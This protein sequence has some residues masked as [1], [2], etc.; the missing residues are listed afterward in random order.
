LISK[1]W[2]AVVG[3]AASISLALTGCSFQQSAATG[4][5]QMS[6]DQVLRIADTGDIPTLDSAKA[7]DVSSMNILNNIQ[8][9]LMR[10]GQDDQPEN[11]IASDYEVSPD[12][13]T[14]TFHLRDDAN[15]S[16]GKPVTADDFRYAWL[17]ALDPKTASQYAYALYPIKN[18]QKYNQ[19][20]ASASQVGIK[21]LDKHTLQVTLERPMLNFISMTTMTVYLP[22]REDIVEKYGSKYGTEADKLVYDGPFTVESW[23][24]QQVILQRNDNYWDS[25]S[26]SLKTV[27]INIIKDLATG[28]NMYNAGQIDIVPLN[29]AFVDAYKQTPDFV[30]VKQ[31]GVYYILLNQKNPFFKNDKIR[32]AITLALDRDQIANRILKD[33]SSPAGSL[34]PPSMNGEANKSF[35]VGGEVVETDVGRAQKLFKE[36]LKELGLSQPPSNIVMVGYDTTARRNVAVNIKEQLRQTLGWDISLD[37]PTW[38]VHLQRAESGNY[39]MMMLGWSADYNDPMQFFE[40]FESNNPMNFSHFSNAKYDQ[41]VEKAKQETN[42][43]QEFLDLSQA[44][45]ILVGTDGEGQAAFVPLFYGGKSYVQ[46]PYVKD[47][48]RHPFGAEYSLKW[49]YITKK[50]Q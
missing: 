45:K 19:G 8:E 48:Y 18:A 42:E 39:D 7:T 31:A 4:D 34:V 44:E 29:D 3:I 13:K 12:K 36:G 41:L 1:N 40:I 32:K 20:K 2:K 43:H 6:S 21:V 5:D 10:Q 23:T 16:D 14:Y 37:S 47:V 22:E 25:N 15:W 38:K 26:V 9:G 33:G 28:I 46:K 24:P 30:S 17:R 35:R 27:Q 49:A 50:K 11:G